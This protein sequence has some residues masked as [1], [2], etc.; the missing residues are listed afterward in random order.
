M[1]TKL[2][3][4][5]KQEDVPVSEIIRKAADLWLRRFPDKPANKKKV[6]TIDAG[7]CMMSAEDMKEALYE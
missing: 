7:A 5:A 1:M 6:P 2:R 3:K 4:V